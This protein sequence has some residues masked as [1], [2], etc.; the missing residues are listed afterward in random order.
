VTV[1]AWGDSYYTDAKYLRTELFL[2]LYC[3]MFIDMLRRS[4]VVAAFADPAST[5]RHDAP[6]VAS[7]MLAPVA[8]HISSLAILAPHG[9]AFLIYLIAV[10]AVLVML[11]DYYESALLRAAGFIGVVEAFLTAPR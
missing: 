1:A 2:T 8:Y 4:W 11:S 6:L 3:A 9:L 7:L 5:G 10:T